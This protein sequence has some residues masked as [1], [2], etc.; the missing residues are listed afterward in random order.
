MIWSLVKHHSIHQGCT[1]LTSY[2]LK[3][4]L[5][6]NFM[7]RNDASTWEFARINRI[8]ILVSTKRQNVLHVKPLPSLPSNSKSKPLSS[9]LLKCLRCEPPPLFLHWP[10]KDFLNLLLGLL[11]NDSA[12]YLCKEAFCSAIVFIF[13]FRGNSNWRKIKSNY[14]K[15]RKKCMTKLKKKPQKSQNVPFFTEKNKSIISFL[16]IP[17]AYTARGVRVLN[18][19]YI[20][21]W[22]RWF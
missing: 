7:R 3:T 14:L 1:L 20:I 19:Y 6:T 10:I 5:L 17:T 22:W 15:I 12:D 2:N 11:R 9:T 4:Y 18:K 8:R 16:G 13:P 21:V